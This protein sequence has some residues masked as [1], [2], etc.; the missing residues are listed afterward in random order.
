MR[1]MR[2]FAHVQVSPIYTETL[3]ELRYGT[4]TVVN[5][6]GQY[7]G[8]TVNILAAYAT[9]C[10]ED[11]GE[12]GSSNAMGVNTVTAQSFPH[13]KG[14]ALRDFEM[15]VYPDFKK[16]IKQYHR[17]DHSFTFKSGSILEFK[18]FENEMAARGQKRKRLFV[19]EANSFPEP[20]WFQLNSR[21]EQSVI[22]YNPSVRFWAHE[23]LIGEPG[24]RTIYSDHR[25][26]PF[27]T[28]EK[29][30]EI[31]LYRDW[32]K[33]DG[34]ERFKVYSRGITGNVE[35]V[36]FPN[37]EMIDDVDFPK[38]EDFIYS[39]DFGYTIDPTAV[40]KTVKIGNTIY[41]K[42]LA[43]E[44]GLSDQSIRNILIADGF[45]LEESILYCE[46][47]RDM[48]RELRNVGIINS[49]FARKGQGSVNAGIELLNQYS[50]KYT[51]NSRNLKREL[52]MYTWERD[53][54]TG[55]SI[56]V[57]VDNNNHA[58]DAIRYGVYSR[59]LK[60]AA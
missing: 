7:S 14:G 18:V 10:A 28:P 52:S 25:H 11:S 13:L 39:V 16:A 51:C 36:I 50:V 2:I 20:V 53:K 42:E 8:K 19:N 3:K 40:M 46:H 27:L 44:T 59:Y 57:P 58:I 60:N 1:I 31:E 23:Q 45:N 47:D 54:F 21:S 26:N 34:G 15:F 37:W 12:P 49:L 48:I 17:T 4:R 9:L 22:D 32:N 56:N 35:G 41:V 55:K 38:D 6:G 29:H 5:Q 33:A 30:R 43:Y 24:V